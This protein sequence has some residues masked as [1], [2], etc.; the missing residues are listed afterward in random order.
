M[1]LLIKVTADDKKRG[2]FLSFMAQIHQSFKESM[3]LKRQAN[4]E[5]LFFGTSAECLNTEATL[6]FLC[7]L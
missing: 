2:Y 6:L 5:R 7:H 3:S 4:T 1:T